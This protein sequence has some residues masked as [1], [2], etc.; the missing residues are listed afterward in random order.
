MKIPLRRQRMVAP[1]RFDGSGFYRNFITGFLLLLGLSAVA[2]FSPPPNATT[3]SVSGQFI[4]LAAD[5]VSRLSL[6]P[7]L[8]TNTDL[9]RLEPALLA[10]SA[11]RIKDSFW[12][13]LGVNAN[14]TWRGQIVLA[15]HP[16]QSL[17]EEVTV[18]SSYDSKGWNY[19]V[20]LPDILSRTRLIRALT[21]VL[22]REYANRSAGPN[23]ITAEVPAWLTDGLAQ[24][25]MADD[26]APVILS[27]P[28]HVVGGLAVNRTLANAKGLDS[29]AAARR[30]LRDQAVLTFAQLSW[31]TGSQLSGADGGVYRASAH[32]FVNGLLG[33]RNG[34]AKLRNFLATLPRYC[35]WQTAFEAAFRADFPRALDVEKWWALQV[36]DFDSHDDGPQWT[37]AVSCRKLDEILHV[38][39]E[40]R[41]SSNALP[42]HVEISLQTAIRSFDPARQN[43]ALHNCLRDLKLAQLRMARPLAILNDRYRQ[44]I[45]G[46]LGESL[47]ASHPVMLGKHGAVLFPKTSR[48]ETLAQLDALDARRRQIEAGLRPEDFKL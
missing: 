27:A 18:V 45:A 12:R 46:Y 44:V 34:P 23:G 37:T 29:L 6:T 39:V 14:T 40:T 20:Q 19:R 33:L 16:A 35:N 41:T 17:D 3:R 38:P 43:A 25:I 5:Q 1:P 2:Q 13:E 26:V 10:I 15:L 9:V 22:L 28:N 48:R 36:V 32:L 47:T 4:V 11:E 42:A 30:Q 31:P 21:G 24:E 8:A 7:H